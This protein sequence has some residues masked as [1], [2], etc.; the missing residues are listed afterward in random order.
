MGEFWLREK[1]MTQLYPFCHTIRT[2]ANAAH[3]YGRPIVAAEAFTSF[4]HFLESPADLKPLGDDALCA[5]LNRLVFHQ[6]THQPQ[7]D[8]KP[9]YQY[10]AGTHI[11]RNLTWWE[12]SRPFFEY[13]ARCQH[14]LQAGRFHA[15]VCYFYGEGAGQFVP[16]KAYLKP[17]LSAGYNFDAINADVLLN[18]LR[19]KEGRLVLPDGPSYHVLV[20]PDND[21]HVARALRKIKELIEAGATVLG[22]PPQ[23]APGLSDGRQRERGTEGNRARAPGEPPR[24]TTS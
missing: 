5:G 24:G 1:L 22:R 6:S 13:W 21:V 19:V 17:A 14:L 16:D 11:D 2:V 15:D 4:S 23:H 9:G 8:F 3:V 10:G 7:L 20:L 18:R 12:M